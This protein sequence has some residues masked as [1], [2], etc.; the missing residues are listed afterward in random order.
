MQAAEDGGAD[1]FTFGLYWTRNRRVFVERHVCAGDDVIVLDVFC[2]HGP[3]MVFAE[4]NDVIQT[5]PA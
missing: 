1:D 2:Q 3:Q 5:L 4:D